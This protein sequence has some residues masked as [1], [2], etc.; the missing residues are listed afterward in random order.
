MKNWIGVNDKDIKFCHGVGSQG[1]KIV[2]FSHRND[3]QQLMK[4]TKDLSRLNLTDIDLDLDD[5]TVSNGT[6]KLKFEENSRP[7]LIMHATD[8]DKH[9]PGIDLSSPTMTLQLR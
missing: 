7:L 9:F 1:H 3:C 8:F 2:K 6:V 4:A 5:G